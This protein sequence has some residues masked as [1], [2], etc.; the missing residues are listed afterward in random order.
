[1]AIQC[2]IIAFPG[3]P[4]GGVHVEDGI[5]IADDN[6][7]NDISKS[8]PTCWKR[9]LKRREFVKETLGISLAEEVLPTSNIQA[10]LFPYMANTRI[11]LS[12]SR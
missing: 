2:D 9:I 5:L 1:M 3:K 8:F 4:Y 12:Q 7:R 6:L 11:V 10:V